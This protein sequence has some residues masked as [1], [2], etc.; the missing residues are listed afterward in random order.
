MAAEAGLLPSAL[1]NLSNTASIRGVLIT[2]VL[3]S[4]S[5]A[6]RRTQN[7]LSSAVNV[8]QQYQSVGCAEKAV[9]SSM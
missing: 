8:H 5:A 7:R 2:D 6:G 9:K 1:W 4:V 3:E